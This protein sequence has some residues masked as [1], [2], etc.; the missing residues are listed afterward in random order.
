M[1]TFN[2]GTSI[3]GVRVPDDRSILK[4]RKNK[5]TDKGL[6]RRYKFKFRGGPLD[7]AQNFKSSTTNRFN[8]L[9]RRKS[10]RKNEPKITNRVF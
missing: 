10:R 5:G 8:V 1:D 4:N 7:E 9:Y 6:K 2:H 3:S